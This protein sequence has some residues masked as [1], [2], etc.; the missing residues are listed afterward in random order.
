MVEARSINIKE[1]TKMLRADLKR[2]WPKIKF[3]VRFE[4]YSMGCN[5]NVTWTDG[6]TQGVVENVASVFSG[7]RFDGSD[8]STYYVRSWL[9]PDGTVAA[10][11]HDAAGYRGGNVTPAPHPQAELVRFSGSAPHCHREISPVYEA[12]CVKAWDGLTERERSVLVRN[13]RFPQWDGH[14]PGYRLAWFFDADQVLGA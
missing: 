2:R 12:A 13:A 11:S 5:I 14:T 3:S 10:A 6:P 8:D 4:K 9:L 7:S 1:A